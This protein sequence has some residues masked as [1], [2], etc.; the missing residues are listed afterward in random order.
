MDVT[1]EDLKTAKDIAVGLLDMVRELA[2]LR[3][4]D[5][6]GKASCD[7]TMNLVGAT[8]HEIKH[9]IDHVYEVMNGNRVP[10]DFTVS[11]ALMPELCRVAPSP[12]FLEQLRSLLAELKGLDFFVRALASAS[13]EPPKI[14]ERYVHSDFQ[15]IREQVLILAKT[16]Y[17]D[18]EITA[19]FNWLHS[20]AAEMLTEVYRGREGTHTTA[21]ILPGPFATP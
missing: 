2:K 8:L 17:V 21:N 16:S 12:F 15:K 11:T 1:L 13:T 18:D 7:L 9:N 19:R 3:G 6:G 10:F 5:D 20:V 4:Q 14:A